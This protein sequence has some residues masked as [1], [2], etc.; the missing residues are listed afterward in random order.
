MLKNRFDKQEQEGKKPTKEEDRDDKRVI[1]KPRS[2]RLDSSWIT[3]AGEDGEDLPERKRMKEM[4][5]L[6]EE[7]VGDMFRDDPE[8]DQSMQNNKGSAEGS[9]PC[10]D[11][12]AGGASRQNQDAS[13]GSTASRNPEGESVQ[14]GAKRRS[15]GD[16]GLD[17]KF[18]TLGDVAET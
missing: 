17:A 6:D 13:M 14:R 9:A 3:K 18:P 4:A 2:G 16:D 1:H 10:T 12:T 15:E 8:G 5:N 11:E 7:D